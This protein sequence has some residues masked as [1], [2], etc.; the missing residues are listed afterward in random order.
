MA[1]N[2]T[3]DYSK[4]FKAECLQHI[5][6]IKQFCMSR[7][8]PFYMTFATAAEQYRYY[9]REGLVKVADGYLVIYHVSD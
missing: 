8:I 7:G 9:E 1:G 4:D 2:N 6:K 3:Y 5:L